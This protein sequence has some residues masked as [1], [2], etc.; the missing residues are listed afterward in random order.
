MIVEDFKV[1]STKLLNLVFAFFPI[2]LILGNLVTNLN[3]LLFCCLGIFYLKS[4]IIKTKFDFPI[5][6]IFLLFILILF[7][8]FLS[9]VESLYSGNYDE[10]ELVKLTKSILFFRYFSRIPINLSHLP[11]SPVKC[12]IFHKMDFVNAFPVN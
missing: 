10:S 11:N 9:F 12:I 1:N 2:S 3:T 6:V 5:K 7:S 4:Q 8:T